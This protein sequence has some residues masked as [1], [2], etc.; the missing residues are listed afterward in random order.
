MSPFLSGPSEQALLS[1]WGALY[2]LT[3]SGPLSDAKLIQLTEKDVQSK[4]ELLFKKN[5]YDVAV[6]I[7]KSQQYDEAGLVDIFR[8][9]GD[10]LYAKGEGRIQG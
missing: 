8:Q 5:L 3:G 7:A 4:L 2:A 1:E 10:H 6:K 9:Y